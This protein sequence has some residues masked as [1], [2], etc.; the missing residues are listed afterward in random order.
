V[1]PHRASGRLPRSGGG[2]AGSAPHT[3]WQGPRP[4]VQIESAQLGPHVR[5]ACRASCSTCVCRG[6]CAPLRRTH[7]QVHGAPRG[8]R[9]RRVRRPNHA[10]SIASLVKHVINVVCSTRSGVSTNS[11][12]GCRP[13]KP[14]KTCEYDS[15]PA[16]RYVDNSVASLIHRSLMSFFVAHAVEC[17]KRRQRSAVISCQR[18]SKSESCV[19]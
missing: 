8:N 12:V 3:P 11:T 19:L 4:I 6:A 18:R 15:H 5:G 1:T 2:P 17:G 7:R 10:H 9:S 16:S 13:Y 14:R